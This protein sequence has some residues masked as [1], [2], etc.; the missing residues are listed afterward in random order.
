M[1]RRTSDCD[2]LINDFVLLQ[3][4]MFVPTALLVISFV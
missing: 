2:C 4:L 1:G 3:W